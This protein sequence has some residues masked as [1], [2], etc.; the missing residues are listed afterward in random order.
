MRWC[1]CGLF[2]LE[3]I[4][5]LHHHSVIVNTVMLMIPPPHIL[6]LQHHHVS[7]VQKSH[8]RCGGFGLD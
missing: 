2:S 8:S 5:N 6:S 7:V 3:N 1:V 4:R